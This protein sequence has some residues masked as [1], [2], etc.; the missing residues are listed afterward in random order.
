M[1]RARLAR[2]EVWLVCLDPT[3]GAEIKKTRPCLV[4]SPQEL[5]DPLRTALVAPL[6]SK[7]FPAP[8]RIAVNFAGVAG[9]VLLDQIRSVDKMRLTRRLGAVSDDE[10]GQVLATLQELFA[11]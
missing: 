1:V 5:H 11:P 2:G 4:V 8:F 3:L 7:G 10:L 6:T 9:L